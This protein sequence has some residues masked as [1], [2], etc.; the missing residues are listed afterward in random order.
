MLAIMPDV[1]DGFIEITV[2]GKVSVDEFEAAVAAIDEIIARH[3]KVNVFEVV[4]RRKMMPPQL[5]WRDL[6]FSLSHFSKFGRYAIVTEDMGIVWIMR[7]FGAFSAMEVRAFATADAEAARAWAQGERAPEKP[8]PFVD[9][10][11][12]ASEGTAGVP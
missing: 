9:F 7:A 1:S 10:R 6:K 5:W 2:D 12:K 3:G 8:E 11:A 4:R